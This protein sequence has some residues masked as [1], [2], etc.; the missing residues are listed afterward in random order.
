MGMDILYYLLAIV[1][2]RELHSLRSCLLLEGAMN[3]TL[4]TVNQS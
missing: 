2:L 1:T 3:D 4:F